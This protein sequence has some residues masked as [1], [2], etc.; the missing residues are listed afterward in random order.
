M[1]RTFL[2]F[3]FM[4]ILLTGLVAETF[5]SETANLATASF[6]TANL[7]A[8][9]K[10]DS[11]NPELADSTTAKNSETTE[12]SSSVDINSQAQNYSYSQ[13]LNSLHSNNPEL[14]L[15][16]EEYNRSL[17]DVKD[18]WGALTPTVD[19]Q[20]SGTYM[21]NPPVDAI[22]LN[23]DDIINSIQW[24]VSSK[25]ASTGQYVK[26]YDGM[27]N[28]LYNFQL[29][30]TQ[31]LYT[32]GKIPNAIALYK[33]T[34]EIRLTQVESKT[35]ELETELKSRLFTLF[36]LKKI[37]QIIEEEK[38]YADRLVTVSED[39]E[40]SGML[41]HQDVVDAKIQ[42]KELEIARRDL[43][44]QIDNQ[45][46]ELSRATGIENLKIEDLNLE[47]QNFI[48][49]D[50]AEAA[51]KTAADIENP[52]ATASTDAD[53]ENPDATASTDA[54]EITQILNAD[55][56][57][58]EEKALSENQLSIKL[59]TQL[60]E[61][62]KIAEKISK[63]SV[64]WKP[65]FALKT[66]LGYAG[67]RFPLLEPNWLKKD[68]YSANFSIGIKTTVWDGGKKVHNVAR[69]QSN[70]KTAQINQEDARVNIKKTLNS[71]W[72]TVDVCT[73]KIG[74]QDLKIEAADSKIAQKQ[75]IYET[76]Y[77]SETD[78]LNA[79]IDRCNQLIEKEKQLLSRGVA[80]LTISYLCK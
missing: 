63:A 54:D 2:L 62:N 21:M 46:L 42:A 78:V 26:I 36:Q 32:W 69:S 48:S 50:N 28:T 37:A 15:L 70:V 6:A 16:Q 52:D 76:G 8:D 13:L 66:S 18:A 31:P 60:E 80:C 73:I 5:P 41:L 20:I 34:S 38:I 49:A 35:E 44:E 25:P 40:K 29:S 67:S 55:R 75:T 30:I 59:V 47:N 23:V 57:K 14:L 33:K 11:G 9:L 58:I 61:V 74:Y 22:Y 3:F 56:T 10:A 53:V 68:D 72:N 1:K 71:Q 7:E 77:G 79:K 27:E 45:L 17:L 19:L 43:T 39:A 51:N 65:D 24:P 64:N 4:M 12:I